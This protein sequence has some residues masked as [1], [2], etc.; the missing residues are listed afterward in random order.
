M[1]SAGLAGAHLDTPIRVHLLDD[2]A[3][4]FLGPV[5]VVHEVGDYRLDALGA[6]IHGRGMYHR[7]GP[8]VRTFGCCSFRPVAPPLGGVSGAAGSPLADVR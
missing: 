1:A 4:Q 5:R 8:N 2:R 7:W 3:G 6:E